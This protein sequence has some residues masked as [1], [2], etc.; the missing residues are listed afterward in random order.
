MLQIC[1]IVILAI[2]TAFASAFVIQVLEKWGLRDKWQVNCQVKLLAQMLSCDFCFGFWISV[3]FSV[4]SAI[5][6]NNIGLIFIPIISAPL[7]RR[8][9]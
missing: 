4:I 3:V 9:L 7:T 1:E 8:I 6:F 5:L 2:G